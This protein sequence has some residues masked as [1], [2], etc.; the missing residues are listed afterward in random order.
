MNLKSILESILFAYGE[1]ITKDRLVKLTKAD[2]EKIEAALR[3]LKEEWKGRGIVLLEKDDEFQ[4]GSNPENSKYVEEL[5]K[6]EFTTELSRAALET[7]AIVA[8]KGPLTRA[9]I[10]YIRGVNSSFTLRNL[11]MRGLVERTENPNDARSY[12]YKVSFDFLKYLGLTNI[13]DLPSYNEF[14]KEKIE[15]GEGI[16]AEHAQ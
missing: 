13:S 1:P 6:E 11:L 2:K 15:I 7:I 3:E 10:E 8:Y 4:L 12:L 14:Q 16:Q 9:K 5:M